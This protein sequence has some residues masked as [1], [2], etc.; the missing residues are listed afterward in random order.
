M[1]TCKIKFVRNLFQNI[2]IFFISVKCSVMFSIHSVPRLTLSS[3][4]R[5]GM[6][7]CFLSCTILLFCFHHKGSRFS[8]YTE[9]PSLKYWIVLT[10]LC[11]ENFQHKEEF[12]T[13]NWSPGTTVR[14]LSEYRRNNPEN[15]RK[16]TWEPR[17]NEQKSTFQW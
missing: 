8:W 7:V 6:L 5:L 14:P 12:C 15:Q 13:S 4:R 11:S 3:L 16:T 1:I 10:F 2:W 9:L 17:K